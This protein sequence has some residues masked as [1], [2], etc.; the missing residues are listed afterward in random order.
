MHFAKPQGNPTQREKIRCSANL[1]DVVRA[2]DING[3]DERKFHKNE[4][5]TVLPA[6]PGRTRLFDLL[7][8]VP[9]K[10]LR[11][12]ARK[13]S[14]HHAATS[15]TC[16]LLPASKFRSKIQNPECE[17]PYAQNENRYRPQTRR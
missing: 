11:Q 16:S 14:L 8:D 17:E 1:Q 9:P 12:E 3:G 15:L 4:P 5:A 10:A 6:S 7:P 13:V 2:A